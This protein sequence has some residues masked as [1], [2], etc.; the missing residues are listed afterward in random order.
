MINI[1]TLYRCFEQSR[2][3]TTDTR[4]CEEGMM[5]FALR[6]ENFDGNSYAAKALELGCSYVVIDNPAYAV[7]DDARVLLVV[8]LPLVPVMPT[9][10]VPN[11]RR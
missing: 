5:F 7:E 1:E 11:T 10:G 6:G 2:G 9:M 3:V 8:V 4:R